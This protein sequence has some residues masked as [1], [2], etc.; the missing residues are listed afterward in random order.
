VGSLFSAA[1][2]RVR[3]IPLPLFDVGLLYLSRK[4]LSEQE[5]WVPTTRVSLA[6]VLCRVFGLIGLDS[7]FLNCP[8]LL[9][10]LLCLIRLKVALHLLVFLLHFRNLLLYVGI[11][12]LQRLHQL[13]SQL[14]DPIE[15]LKLLLTPRNKCLFLRKLL[16]EK[17]HFNFVLL[18]EGVSF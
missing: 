15:T 3:L 5:G 14:I 1:L 7:R 13:I 16:L 18:T 10:P 12:F 9:S 17:V 2:V 6:V 4:A 11:F 8:P